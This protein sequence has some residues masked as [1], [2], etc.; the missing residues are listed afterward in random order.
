MN[1]ATQGRLAVTTVT[2]DRATG[3]EACTVP[4]LRLEP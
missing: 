3:H 1:T 2:F 4:L